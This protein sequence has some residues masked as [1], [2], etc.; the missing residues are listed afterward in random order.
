MKVLTCIHS[1]ASVHTLWPSRCLR[2]TLSP[3]G[4][5]WLITISPYLGG[6]IPPVLLI[7]EIFINQNPDRKAETQ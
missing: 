5:L 4:L 7:W 6:F 3:Q 1:E 2:L